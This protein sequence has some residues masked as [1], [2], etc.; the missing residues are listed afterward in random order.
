MLTPK[1]LKGLPDNIIRIFEELEEEVIADVARRI[2]EGMELTETADYQIDVLAKMGYKLTDIKKE[3]AKSIDKSEKEVEKLLENSSY[4]SYQNDKELYKLGGKTLPGINDNPMMNSFII[5]VIK[6]TKG[7]L[8]NI[9]NTLGFVD[10]GKFKDL[11]KFYKDT[12][13]YAVFQLG[14]DAFDYNT[15]LKNT[16]KKLSDSGIRTIDYNS[17]R[18]YHIDSAVRMTVMTGVT[19]ITGRMSEMNADMMYQDLMEI[20]AHSGA[21]PS[22]KE[23]QGQIVS[24]SGKP[25][26]LTLDD[27]GYNSGDGFQGYNCRHGWFPYFEGISKPAYLQ[28]D[29]DNI[30]PPP[31]EYDGK[32]YTAYEASQKQRY[33]GRQ[34]KKTKRNLIAYDAAGLKE[35]FT[36]AS[37][38]LRRQKEL[39]KDFSRKAKL[40]QKLDRTGVYGYNRSISSKSVWAERKERDY[41]QKQ[42]SYVMKGKK[43]FIPTN[44]VFKNTKTIAGKNSNKELRDRFRLEKTYGGKAE[45]WDKKVG[46]IQSDKFIFDIHWYELEGK[47]YEVKLKYRGDNK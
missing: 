20:T 40:R 29:L 30:D 6:Q 26:Y 28:S 22:H 18:K 32:V 16:V 2:A 15:V 45:D 31:F 4:L 10:G 43:R 37:I 39:Y 14:S 23:W 9:T 21:R 11:D 24:R 7:E 19:Q 13:D 41:L 33:I 17:G 42:F 25:G 36:A 3:I 1:Y 46:K 12:L 47:Q 38:K 35:D 8:R 34:I 5:G 27:I 44:T